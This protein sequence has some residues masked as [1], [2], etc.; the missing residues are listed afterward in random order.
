[1]KPLYYLKNKVNCILKHSNLG[2]VGFFAVRD[3]E[4]N[5]VMFEP[6]TGESGIYSITHDELHSLPLMLH[7]NIYE[8]FSNKISYINKEGIEIDVPKE[9]NKIFFPL[10]CGFHWIY[11]WPKM[12]MNSGLKNGNV[13]SNEHTLPI[14]TKKIFRD[15]EVLG[16]YGS[17]F[18]T[19]P[20]NFL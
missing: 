2:G 5:E 7:K 4:V 16:N 20:K 17:Q 11:L 1:M 9:Y 15:K 12:F 6:W 3:I 10:E 14:V 13:N 19:T 8:T 18:N